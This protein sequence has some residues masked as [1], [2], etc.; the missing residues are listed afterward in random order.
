MISITTAILTAAGKPNWTFILIAPILPL[1]IIGYW[2]FIPRYGAVGAS[3]V[4]TTLAIMGAMVTVFSIYHLW[5]ITP[6]LGTVLRSISVCGLAYIS[7]S[8]WNADGILLL[9]KLAVIGTLIILGL[10]F[11]GEFSKSEV[12]KIKSVFRRVINSKKS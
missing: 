12:D 2:F 11:L 8:W 5:R 7:A 9:F 1:A 6:S 4:F 10:L 3:I